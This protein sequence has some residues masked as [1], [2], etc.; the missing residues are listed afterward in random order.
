VR[1]VSKTEN[2]MRPFIFLILSSMLV[3]SSAIAAQSGAEPQ[4]RHGQLPQ[5]DFD[6][7]GVPPDKT[8]SIILP[9]CE[10]PARPNVHPQNFYP[11][12]S[13]SLGE[14]GTTVLLL[15][16]DQTGKVLQ[17]KIKES[18]GFERLDKVAAQVA[19]D[20]WRFLPGRINGAPSQMDMHIKVIFKAK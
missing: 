3:M 10:D 5:G 11:A 4:C 2:A 8:A 17:A 7:Y 9:P 12:I 20:K 16:V 13:R 14:E 1:F 19:L 15:T 6:R 18:S